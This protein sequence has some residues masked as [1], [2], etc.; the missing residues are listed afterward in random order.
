[1]NDQTTDRLDG[2]RTEYANTGMVKYDGA[3]W[4]ISQVVVLRERLAA[5]VSVPPPADQ[6]ALRDRIAD[7]AAPFF[8]NFAD[9]EAAK[10]NAKE[11][12]TAVLAV[13]PEQADRA[14]EMER[15]RERHKASLRRA[16]QMNNELMEEV[17][18][19]A[20][21]TER[22]VLWSVYN[23][24]HKRALTAE[25]RAESME[26]HDDG[27]DT[28]PGIIVR[29]RIEPAAEEQPAETQW[30][31]ERCMLCPP[32]TRTRRLEDHMVQVHGARP[33]A[34]PAVGEQ[35]ETQE[36]RHIGGRV[37]A[38]DCP[39]CTGTNP[40]YPFLCPGPDAP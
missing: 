23:E 9:E 34:L 7:T 3:V 5:A 1:M 16:D 2:L 28:G 36:A 17:Q 18:R 21:G 24:M 26:R 32:D 6:T 25:A 20:A 10:V 37:N 11:L 19:Y 15:M 12:A 14:A 39:A 27:I 29:R 31:G 38:E 22:P 13:L 8:A 4:L 40:P 33:A 35:P 30:P